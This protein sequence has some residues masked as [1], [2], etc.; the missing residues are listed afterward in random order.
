MKKVLRE[1]LLKSADD[2]GDVNPRAVMDI[3]DK[4]S[5]EDK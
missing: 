3:F 1:K 4:V 5:E 2:H